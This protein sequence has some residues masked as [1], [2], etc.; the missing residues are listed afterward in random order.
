MTP[1]LKTLTLRVAPWGTYPSVILLGLI[2]HQLFTT[3]ELPSS[4]AAGLSVAAGGVLLLLFEYY[5]PYRV[6]WTPSRT[7]VAIDSL[8]LA[9]V[10]GALP[11]GLSLALAFWLLPRLPLGLTAS[12]R[13]IWPHGWPVI[14]Q[15]VLIII[16]SDLLRYGLHVA[17][18]RVSFLWRFHSLHH[19]P[20]K[21]Y[22]LN[23]GRFHPAEKLFQ[24][25]LDVAPFLV[26]G[27]AD[28]VI[29]IF[30]VFYSLNALLQHS[31]THMRLGA[32]NYVLSTAELHRWHHAR[33]LSERPVNYGNNTI[34]WDWLF[35]TR[36]LPDVAVT[37]VGALESS[38]A[39]SHLEQ[40]LEPLVPRWLVRRTDG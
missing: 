21:V 35:G 24:Y 39:P 40:L 6:D 26:L 31:N 11:T 20:T 4:V 10:Q 23:A 38:P 2:S 18:H 30:L 19:A 28:D 37:S 33:D 15:V 36:F 7:D 17:A 22:W 25:F 27:V 16:T 34:L 13:S 29:A 14:G 9:L 5:L 8:Y 3:L 12:V 32:L 1:V